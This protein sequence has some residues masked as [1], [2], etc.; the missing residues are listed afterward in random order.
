MKSISLFPAV[1]RVGLLALVAAGCESSSH[2]HHE[3]HGHGAHSANAMS[4]ASTPTVSVNTD[5]VFTPAP[6][7]APQ[8]DTGA[9]VGYDKTPV[10]PGQKWR[11]HDKDRPVPPIVTP[12]ARFSHGAPPPSD[13]TVLFGG[14]DLTQWEL[15]DG[16]PAPWTVMNGFF[17]VAPK[18]GAIQTRQEFGDC[19]LHIEFATPS[20]VEGSSQ[21]RGN[22]GVFFHAD[23]EVQVLDS[24]NNR[25]YADGQVGALY[26]QWPPLANPVK[27]PGEWNSYDIVFEAPRF[28]T[29]GKLSRPGYL[30]VIL[31]G[32]LMHNRKELNGP[33]HHQVVDPYKPYNSRGKISLQ[34]HGNTTR[35][36]NIWVRAIG[37]YN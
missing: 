10:I 23:F 31:N 32:V 13:A 8:Q 26:G 20:L 22:S 7:P 37:E 28:D 24:Y 16:K 11:V 9:G 25:T 27:G 14:R 35:F 19:Q 2:H 3:H 12:G 17:Q 4:A 30:T 21:G 5:G 1:V 34:D 33:T 18:A 15:S 36:R 29:A 6:P